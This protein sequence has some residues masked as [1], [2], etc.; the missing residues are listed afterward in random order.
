MHTDRDTKVDR[1]RDYICT[2]RCLALHMYIS[3]P[4]RRLPFLSFDLDKSGLMH[5]LLGLH[6]PMHKKKKPR[7]RIAILFLL[8]GIRQH[9][10]LGG[11]LGYH[12]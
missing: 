6:T 9:A 8:S 11:I 3:P 4:T 1:C 7:T 10:R 2:Y 5:R 12:I